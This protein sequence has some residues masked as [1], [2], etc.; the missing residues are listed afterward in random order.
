MRIPRAAEIISAVRLVCFVEAKNSDGVG[1]F[2][3][4]PS[5]MLAILLRVATTTGNRRG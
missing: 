2:R 4:L 1:E 3:R 5:S